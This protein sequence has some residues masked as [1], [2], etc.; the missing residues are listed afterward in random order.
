MEKLE[1]QKS[2]ILKNNIKSKE[3]ILKFKK[4]S[5]EEIFF[6]GLFLISF[7]HLLKHPRITIIHPKESMQLI[8]DLNRFKPQ[9]ELVASIFQEALLYEGYKVLT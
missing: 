5:K 6:F 7:A 1:K 2:L 9:L 8:M 4:K 3:R